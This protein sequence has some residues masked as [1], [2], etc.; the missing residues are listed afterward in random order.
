MLYMAIKIT[1]YKLQSRYSYI[2]KARNVFKISILFD[3]CFKQNIKTSRLIQ[4]K[5][6]GLNINKYYTN[7]LKILYKIISYIDKMINILLVASI[8]IAKISTIECIKEKNNLY[9]F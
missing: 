8:Y 7:P 1:F 2:L 4:I 6:M 9:R 3:K 5:L